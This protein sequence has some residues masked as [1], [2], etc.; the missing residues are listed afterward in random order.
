MKD[1]L[2]YNSLANLPKFIIYWSK[3]NNVWPRLRKWVLTK[4]TWYFN[5][6]SSNW[7]NVWTFH[8]WWVFDKPRI[9]KGFI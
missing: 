4:E 3:K 6:F 9:R 7:S 5:I 1:I 2:E 8:D